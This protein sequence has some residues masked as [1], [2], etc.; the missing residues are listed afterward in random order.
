MDLQG[1]L[2]QQCLGMAALI[3]ANLKGGGDP[4]SNS[5]ISLLIATLSVLSSKEASLNGA[6]TLTSHVLSL[7]LELE[8]QNEGYFRSEETR[9]KGLIFKGFEEKPALGRG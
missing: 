6:L 5:P 8:T 3:S 1:F 7:K 9:E 2:T 4:G